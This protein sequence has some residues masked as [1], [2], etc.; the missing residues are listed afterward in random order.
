MGK[1]T[2][3]AKEVYCQPNPIL[4]L[5]FFCRENLKILLKDVNE[6]KRCLKENGIVV[7]GTHHEVQFV[8]KVINCCKIFY[9]TSTCINDYMHGNLKIV[10][11]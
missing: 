4:F 9:S 5:F 6:Q 2:A 11:T 7:D 3:Q 8:G 10:Q 1:Q